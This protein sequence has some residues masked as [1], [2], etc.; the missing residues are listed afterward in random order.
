LTEPSL[1]L[2]QVVLYGYVVTRLLHF[3]AYFT[4][5]THDLRATMW[6]PGS[7]IILFMTGWT[8]VAA[9]GA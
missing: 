8:L 1:L 3:G 2:A 7:L 4:A 6:T 9:L 5:Q